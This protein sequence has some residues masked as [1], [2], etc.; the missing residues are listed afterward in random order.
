MHGRR[1]EVV[2]GIDYGRI[3]RE[4]VEWAPWRLSSVGASF[5]CT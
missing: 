3:G 4:V 1:G 5:K 2:E